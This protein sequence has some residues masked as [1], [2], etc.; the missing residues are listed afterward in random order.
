MMFPQPQQAIEPMLLTA[1]Q[2][3]RALSVS[4]R[5][6]FSLTQAKEIPA[7]RFGRAV[8]YDPTDL[9]AWIEKAKRSEFSC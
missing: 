7:V 4:E 3:A 9:R 5:T 2:A 1:R 6:L 8:R